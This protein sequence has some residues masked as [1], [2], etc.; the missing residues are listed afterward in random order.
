[1]LVVADGDNVG[2]D[3]A[4]YL[5]EILVFVAEYG[6][7]YYL[8]GLDYGSALVLGDDWGPALGAGHCVVCGDYD[9][10]PGV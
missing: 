6:F 10:E 4:H 8:E 7:V 2:F 1:V 5:V 3:G 9:H